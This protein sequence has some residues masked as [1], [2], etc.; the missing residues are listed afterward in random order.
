MV[1]A[2]RLSAWLPYR[3]APRTV[4]RTR[5]RIPVPPDEEQTG[6]ALLRELGRDAGQGA[7]IKPKAQS[8]CH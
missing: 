2:A 6:E 7:S 8:T 5:V 1:L 4:G 3:R